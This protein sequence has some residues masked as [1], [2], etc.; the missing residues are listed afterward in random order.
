MTSSKTSPNKANVK[1]RSS[2]AYLA[3]YNSYKAKKLARRERRLKKIAR[4]EMRKQTERETDKNN[5]KS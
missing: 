2:L 5:N 4:Q 3:I 1:R